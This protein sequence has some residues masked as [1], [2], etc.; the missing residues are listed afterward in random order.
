M[1]KKPHTPYWIR[2]TLAISAGHRYY[3][4]VVA[5]IAFV[6]TATFTFPFV[7]VLIPAVL[8][9]PRRWLLLGLLCGLASGI[10]A[11]VLVEIFQ[12]LGKELI[13]ARYPELVE[14]GSWRL[15]AEWL[16]DYGLVAIAV[17]AGSP[18]PQTP[19][20]FFYS[21]ADPSVTGILI[22]VGIGKTVKYVFL[23]WLTAHY[24]ARFI[25]YR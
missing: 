24:P 21:L 17:I 15:A 12:Y 7:I 2:K 4:L 9:C 18:M 19:V 16:H 3:P 14:T 8:I 6:S 5:A 20:L 25:E 1:D 22:A 11:A 13:I 10:G 23:A